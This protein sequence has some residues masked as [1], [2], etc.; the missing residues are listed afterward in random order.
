MRFYDISS[1]S[2]IYIWNIYNRYVC[3]TSKKKTCRANV[4]EATSIASTPGVFVTSGMYV[5]SGVAR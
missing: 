1:I 2:M 3:E 4:R 5:E